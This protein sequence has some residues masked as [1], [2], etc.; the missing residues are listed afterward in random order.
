MVNQMTNFT[1]M[2]VK[3]FENGKVFRSIHALHACKRDTHFLSFIIHVAL[4]PRF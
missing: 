2:I 1:D 3:Y 4:Q